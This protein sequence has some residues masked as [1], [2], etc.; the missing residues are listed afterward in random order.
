MKIISMRKAVIAV[1]LVLG[2]ASSS[3]AQVSM[4]FD[5]PGARI[6]INLQ[7]YPQLQPIPGYPVY[8]A[9]GVNSNYFFYDGLY[10]VYDGTNWYAS[11]WYNGPWSL[12]DPLNVPVY[13]LRV[14][15]RYYHRPPAFFHG[16]RASDPPHWGDH[17]GPSWASHRAGWD[18][19]NRNS[20]PAPAP[21]PTYQRQ[22][23]GSR[24]PQQ[25]AQQPARPPQPNLNA[26]DN[27]QNGQNG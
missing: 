23:S 27:K 20:A 22:Y 14:P 8:Y 17:W 18:Q 1:G 25:P 3:F 4:D 6:G 21:L 9:P 19:W 10:W 11:S 13:L 12:V 2:S 16:W 26:P 5:I 7:V 15:V 24:Y